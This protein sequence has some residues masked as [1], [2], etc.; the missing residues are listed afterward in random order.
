MR[1]LFILLKGALLL[2]SIGI[3]IGVSTMQSNLVVPMK[4]SKLKSVTAQKM[5]NLGFAP[6]LA[7][8]IEFVANRENLSPDFLVALIFTESRFDTKAVSSKGYRGL[9]QIPHVIYDPDANILIGAQIFNQKLTMAHGDTL[10]AIILYKGYGNERDY[11]R[12][13]IQAEKVLSLYHRLRK[14]EVPNEP[15]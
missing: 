6:T 14:M 7:D 15:I 3:V 5:Q 8:S 13:K 4:S 12:G 2:A 1:N 9:M 11:E 10:K